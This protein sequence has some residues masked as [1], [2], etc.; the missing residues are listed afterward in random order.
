MFW[1]GSGSLII[2]FFSIRAFLNNKHQW[3]TQI[4]SK[5]RIYYWLLQGI[6]LLLILAGVLFFMLAVVSYFQGFGIHFSSEYAYHM[7]IE[8]S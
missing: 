1:I 2:I 3:T 6:T 7:H 4:S 8:T 5:P